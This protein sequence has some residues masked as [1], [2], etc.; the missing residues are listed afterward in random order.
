MWMLPLYLHV[1]QNSNYILLILMTGLDPILLPVLNLRVLDIIDLKSLIVLIC[2]FF[3]EKRD[4][5]SGYNSKRSRDRINL[6]SMS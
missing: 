6:P 4:E 1:N 2:Y 5:E 3:S